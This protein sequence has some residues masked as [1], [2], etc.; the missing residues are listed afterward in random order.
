MSIEL[1]ADIVSIYTKL[2][3]EMEKMNK[4]LKINEFIEASNKLYNSLSIPDKNKILN[5]KRYAK[6]SSGIE[7]AFQA[8]Y[9]NNT[10][11][12]YK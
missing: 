8:I 6:K 3:S 12:C 7:N 2:F 1:P 10:I 11:A 4:E 5:H 9:I